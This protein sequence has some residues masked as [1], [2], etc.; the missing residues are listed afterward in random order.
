MSFIEKIILFGDYEVVPAIM[1]NELL[2][3]HVEI[4]D[5]TLVDVNG[6]EDTMA[7]MCSSGTTGLPKGVELTHVNFL[8]LTEHLR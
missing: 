7:I 4:D 3:V 2:K 5:F 6:A 8:L 1:Y